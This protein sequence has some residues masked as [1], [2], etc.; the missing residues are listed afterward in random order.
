MK[1]SLEFENKRSKYLNVCQENSYK[2]RCKCS[3]IE[4]FIFYL[5]NIDL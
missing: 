5:K 4:L 2:P 3:S 1:S